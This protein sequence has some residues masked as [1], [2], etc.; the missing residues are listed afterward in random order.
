[1]VA[2]T[3]VLGKYNFPSTRTCNTSRNDV[4]VFPTLPRFLDQDVSF[5]KKAFGVPLSSPE[6]QKTT[7]EAGRESFNNDLDMEAVA[8]EE[9]KH[10]SHLER[11]MANEE[12]HGVAQSTFDLETK[13]PELGETSLVLLPLE[14]DRISKAKKRAYVKAVFLKPKLATDRAFQLMFLR[15]TLF[16]VPAAAQRICRF[17]QEKLDLFGE[18]KLVTKITLADLTQDDIDSVLTTGAG[19]ILPQRDRSGR[20]VFFADYQY[21]DYRHWKNIVRT[22]TL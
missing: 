9:L 3:S 22:V 18:D 10:R 1:M 17:F 15:A 2:T 13:T 12:L 8:A 14:L 16:D 4:C 6:A 21:I 7:T 5:C 20:L 19:H 11:E